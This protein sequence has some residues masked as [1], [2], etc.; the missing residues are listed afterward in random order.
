MEVFKKLEKPITVFTKQ[1]YEGLPKG[2]GLIIEEESENE[3][4]GIWA[5]MLGTYPVQI[6]KNVCKPK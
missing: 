1:E 3:Y 6:P 5:S 2:S 4:L